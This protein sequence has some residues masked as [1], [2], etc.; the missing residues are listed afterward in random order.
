MG[1]IHPRHVLLMKIDVET[2]EPH[3][4]DGARALICRHIV[5]NV[6]MEYEEPLRQ[7]IN[8]EC[9]TWGMLAWMRDAGYEVTDTVPGARPLDIGNWAKVAGPD[10][11]PPNLH[12]RQVHS[13]QMSKVCAGLGG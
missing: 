10:K 3:V 2:F 9:S 11:F 4:L 6:I 5:R 1:Y 8:K 12:F 7:N 13:A